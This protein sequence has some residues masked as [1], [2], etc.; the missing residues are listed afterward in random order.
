MSLIKLPSSSTLNC[1]DSS[2]ISSSVSVDSTASTLSW[3]SGCSI[4]S[5][6][7]LGCSFSSW[8]SG[9]SPVDVRSALSGLLKFPRVM[10]SMFKSF[11]F[12][13]IIKFI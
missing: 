8:T 7:T 12:D 10:S 1:V 2:S 5:F 6:S 3:F 4:I 11:S 9:S 13:I